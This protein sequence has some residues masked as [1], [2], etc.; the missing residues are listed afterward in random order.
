MNWFLKIAAAGS[1]GDLARLLL[2][3]AQRG[4][5]INDKE[6]EL[7]RKLHQQYEK[8][9]T[10]T[11]MFNALAPQYRF[12]P[13][14]NARVTGVLRALGLAPTKR[15]KQKKKAPT[16]GSINDPE[17]IAK[18][19]EV[20]KRLGQKKATAQELGVSYQTV[21]RIVSRNLKDKTDRDYLGEL[22]YAFWG[23]YNMGLQEGLKLM[24]QHGRSPSEAIIE[25]IDR[26]YE[27]PKEREK[28][29]SELFRKLNLRDL[30]QQNIEGPF[31]RGRGKNAPSQQQQSRQILLQREPWEQPV[32]PGHLRSRQ[33]GH[34]M[35]QEEIQQVINNYQ[36]NA[37]TEQEIASIYGISQ[38]EVERILAP[39]K[40][41]QIPALAWRIFNMLKAA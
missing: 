2:K 5:G 23:T 35:T 14:S 25:L 32:E 4:R 12:E 16:P 33:P 7:I 19:L 41:Q 28:A 10:I 31:L 6:I 3:I 20:Y 9:A 24:Q 13:I 1:E 29:K 36:S 17:L 11:R 37:L 38:N 21:D 22:N 40:Q 8:P 15:R 39:Y 18:V 30:M 34:I 27:E 26:M